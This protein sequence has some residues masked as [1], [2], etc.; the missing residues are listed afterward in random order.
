MEQPS[1]GAWFVVCVQNDNYAASLEVRKIYKGN[2]L[3]DEL[4]YTF[5]SRE[6]GIGFRKTTPMA[7]TKGGLDF[8]NLSPMGVLY[9]KIP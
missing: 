7:G 1:Q 6:G 5:A 4:A 8:R 9:G 3:W 2:C